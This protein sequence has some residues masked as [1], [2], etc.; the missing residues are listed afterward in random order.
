MF[1]LLDF[2]PILPDFGLLF[3]STVT[4]LLF[5]GIV[6]RFAFKPIQGALRKREDDIQGA[7]D[8]AKQAREEMAALQADNDRILA[9]AREERSR[10]LKES[11]ETGDRMIAESK[12]KAKAEAQKIVESARLEIENQTKKA[13]EDVKNQVGVM[14]LDIAE[15]VLRKQLADDSSQRA[16]VDELVNEI[17]LN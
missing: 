8:Q 2:N 13:L 11:K 7:L 4:F 3:W 6:G 17:K 16:Y 15:K 1:F 9:E 14:A 5:W 12:D 10:I